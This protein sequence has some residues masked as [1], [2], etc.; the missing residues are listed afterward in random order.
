MPPTT[1]P[2]E[3]V[4]YL[5]FLPRLG[6]LFVFASLLL[7]CFLR[8]DTPTPTKLETYNAASR[9]LGR[10]RSSSTS[11]SMSWRWCFLIF[12]VEVALFFPP[13]HLWQG[14]RGTRNIAEKRKRDG[15]NTALRDSLSL[16][17][18]SALLEPTGDNMAAPEVGGP[19]GRIVWSLASSRS[20]VLLAL[21]DL[22]VFFAV[23]LVGFAFVAPWRPRLGP[24]GPSPGH[25]GPTRR[26]DGK[27]A[28]QRH[29]NVQDIHARLLRPFRP[30]V[31]AF[32]SRRST[33]SR[34]GWMGCRRLPV[35][36]S[37]TV[38]WRST[39]CTALRAS[40]ISSRTRRRPS[41]GTAAAES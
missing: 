25:A 31:T 35:S 12:E 8:A 5:A 4:A 18:S 19:D 33:G 27:V 22:G 17:S 32:A 26:L 34:S 41:R 2:T 37:R 1:P 23:V 10:A 29:M 11:G 13:G 38:S 15:N 40:I 21:A 24:S 3:I 7:G 39:C 16:P 6:F 36:C 20:V 14:G 30:W 28:T 9:R